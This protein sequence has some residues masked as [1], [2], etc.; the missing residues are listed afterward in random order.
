[1]LFI[2]A[3][4]SSVEAA[5]Q[6]CIWLVAQVRARAPFWRKE[7]LAD[8]GHR[9]FEPAPSPGGIMPPP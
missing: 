6:A 4:S 1:V 9:W 8:G 2:A 5:E 3:A 7:I